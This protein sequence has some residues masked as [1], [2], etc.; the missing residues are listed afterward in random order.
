MADEQTTTTDQPAPLPAQVPATPVAEDDI[1]KEY[2]D[3]TAK[4]PANAGAL[5]TFASE[6][7]GLHHRADEIAR[8]LTFF[9][10]STKVVSN[11]DGTHSLFTWKEAA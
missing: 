10:V 11:G 7:D 8:A 5:V 9:G 6:S 1:G 2:A 4:V 3:P